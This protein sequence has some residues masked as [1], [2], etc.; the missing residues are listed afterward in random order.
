[1]TSPSKWRPLFKGARRRW[2]RIVHDQRAQAGVVG[3][4]IALVLVS[5]TIFFSG[6]ALGIEPSLNASV[7]QDAPRSEIGHPSLFIAIGSAPRNSELRKSARES[8]LKW[9]PQ[10][11]LVSYRF[12]SDAPP[13][14]RE[15]AMDPPTK[16]IWSGLQ[17]ESAQHQDLVLQPLRTGYGNK[18]HN[19]YAQRARYQVKW[20]LEN[21]PHLDFFLRIDDD[22]FL[23]LDKLIYELKSLP[24]SQF[25][26][27]RFWCREGRNRADENFMLLS[28]DVVQLLANDELV[29]TIIPYDDEVTLGWNLGYW[30]WMFNLTIFDDQHR[31][32]GQQG[33]LTDY[34][35]QAVP[36]KSKNLGEFCDKHM[37]AHHVSAKTMLA[38]FKQT[39][40][41]LLYPLPERRGPDET[42][43]RQSQ[44]FVPARHSTSLPDLLITRSAH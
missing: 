25:L 18:E 11:L 22:S 15:I 28:R 35:H 12:F 40:I 21:V 24:R 43:P 19:A 17:Q 9:L 33:Y 5:V 10:D 42:C 7:D 36:N 29:G 41:P 31:L 30:S 27:G 14:P 16:P 1:M 26:W 38:A 6:P 39:R 13:P 8:W 34:M 32:D 37:Y 23:C 2:L 20:A 4:L 44:S 3:A